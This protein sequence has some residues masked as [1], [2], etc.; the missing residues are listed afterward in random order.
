METTRI[1]ISH[2][3]KS[4]YQNRKELGD[5]SGL[6]RSIEVTGQITPLIV[7]AGGEACQFVAGHRHRREL[8][9]DDVVAVFSKNTK[10]RFSVLSGSCECELRKTTQGTVSSAGR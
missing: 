7:V 4:S 10:E 5:V 6:A 9:K 1:Q 3:V 2:C 8:T